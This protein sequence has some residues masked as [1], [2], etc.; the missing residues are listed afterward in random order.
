MFQTGYV[1]L[2]RKIVRRRRGPGLVALALSDATAFSASTHIDELLE[3]EGERFVASAYLTFFDRLPDPHGLHANLCALATGVSKF[4]LVFNL[5]ASLEG[6][7]KSKWL[8]GFADAMIDHA[9]RADD[10]SKDVD[11]AR[12]AA[13]CGYLER[14]PRALLSQKAISYLAEQTASRSG[15]ALLRRRSKAAPAARVAPAEWVDVT[16]L[17]EKHDDFATTISAEIELVRS[18]RDVRPALRFCFQVEEGFVEIEPPQLAWL[19]DAD[20]AVDAYAEKIREAENAQAPLVEV[21]VPKGSPFFHPFQNRDILFWTASLGSRREALLAR[22]RETTPGLILCALIP[23]VHSLDDAGYSEQEKDLGA[24][25]RRYLQ[26]LSSHADLLLFRSEAVRARV[27]ALQK[28]EGW[29]SP[30]S[31]AAP[32]DVDIV[33]PLEDAEEQ[34]FLDRHQIGPAFVLCADA[35]QS[36]NDIDTLYRAWLLARETSGALPQLVLCGAPGPHTQDL[37]DT[38]QRDPRVSGALIHIDANEAERASLYRRALFTVVSAMTPAA[39]ERLAESLDRGK[40]CLAT[41]LP[42]LRDMAGDKAVYVP[43]YDVRSWS[44]AVPAQANDP[45]AIREAEQKV[46]ESRRPS[47]WADVAATLSSQ[48]ETLGARSAPSGAIA[49]PSIRRPEPTIWMDL[50]LTFMEWR[51]HVT[52]IPRAEM[53]FAYYLNKLAKGTRYFAHA[54]GSQNYFFEIKPRYLKWLFESA[55]LTSAYKEFNAFWTP[56]E[57]A[58]TDNRNPF[59][60][61]GGPAPS[62]P[63]YLPALPPNTVAFFAAIDQDGTGEVNRV[64]DILPLIR[65]D[66][67]VMSAQLI[68]DL[69]PFLIPQVHDEWTCRG[70]TPFVHFVSEHFDHLLFGGRT[71]QRDAIKIQNDRGWRTPPSDFIE[72]GSDLAL[73]GAKVTPPLQRARSPAAERRILDTLGITGDFVMTVGSLEPRKNHQILYKAYLRLLESDALQQPLQMVFVGRRGWKVDDLLAAIAADERVKG[74]LLILAPTDRELE[75]LYF[76][77]R[78]T[79]LP[80]FYEGWSLTLPESLSYGKLC[81]VSDV[82]PLRETGVD[83]VDYIHPLDTYAWADRIAFY[84][85]NPDEVRKRE[86]TIS[87]SWRPRTWEQSTEMLIERL[88]RAHAERFVY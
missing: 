29:R 5:A 70:Y 77:C 1:E 84:A 57:E 59:A 66:Q 6:R 61:L 38:I 44:A 71:A 30:P 51:G 63:A 47:S 18:L 37:R 49:T 67:G 74:K 79:L 40:L 83:L 69:T 24:R 75:A 39:A 86:K 72:F 73:S 45:A 43:A 76:N 17:L 55:D 23:A 11:P 87:Q 36:S 88:H 78:F 14:A 31:L 3:Q 41:D 12:A 81:L 26:W 28:R 25:S 10:Q 53:T 2:I 80:S 42:A 62:H 15:W 32:L 27:V 54:R 50:T 46:R 56:Q 21:V 68:Y 48:V 85:N 35:F 64:K 82:D 19:L 34:A 9:A 22:V 4:D 8:P 33:Q 65:H 13:I 58:G 20:N 7:L 60:V 52:G 16:V